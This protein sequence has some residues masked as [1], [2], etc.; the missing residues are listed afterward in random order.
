MSAGARAELSADGWLFQHFPIHRACRDGDLVALMSLVES[1]RAHLSA[2]DSCYGWTPIHWAAHYGQLECVVH[3]V[4]RGCEVNT[5][6]SRF[7]QTPTH[8][9]AFGGHPHCVVW[10]TQAGADINK[11]DCVGEAP[12]HKAARC[13]SVECIQVLLIAGAEPRLRNASGQTAADLAKANGFHDCFGAIAQTQLCRLAVLRDVAPCGEGQHCRKRPLVAKE[14]ASM[15]KARRAEALLPSGGGGVEELGAVNMELSSDSDPNTEEPRPPSDAEP[16]EPR[17]SLPSAA[18]M[19]GS[20]H[21][22]GGSGSGRPE[23]WRLT[24]A[25]SLLYGHYH[26]FGDTAEDLSDSG[27]HLYHGS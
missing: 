21:L 1:N 27:V 2:E 17:L 14:T 10:L 4:Q 11:Q 25:D 6:T 20:L 24:G 19:C 22:A 26:G 12:I 8:T 13:G 15:K 5:V 23:H 7:N 18:D 3:L 9:A 16:D